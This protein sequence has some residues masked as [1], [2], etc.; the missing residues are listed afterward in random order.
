MLKKSKGDTDQQVRKAIDP[1]FT[2]NLAAQRLKVIRNFLIEH[3]VE[4]NRF[5]ECA[6]EVVSPENNKPSATLILAD[7]AKST[8]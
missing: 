3:K 5:E 1:E 2:R 8:S 6:P 4:E 7:I